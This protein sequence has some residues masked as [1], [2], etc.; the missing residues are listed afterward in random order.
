MGGDRLRRQQTTQRYRLRS[1]GSGPD[2]FTT[3][4][5]CMC[6]S[7]A[8]RHAIARPERIAN[9]L[10]ITK[11]CRGRAGSRTASFWRFSVR[12]STHR[13]ASAPVGRAPHPWHARCTRVQC[14]A[15]IPR[16]IPSHVRRP[17]GALDHTPPGPDPLVGPPGRIV[18]APVAAPCRFTATC[19]TCCHR[20]PSVR[21]LHALEARAQV[22][23]TIIVAIESEDAARRWAAARLV[24]D[25]LAALPPGAVM[26]VST[27]ARRDRFAWEHRYLL[28]PTAELTASATSWRSGRHGSI[29]SYVSLD[30]GAGGAA[31]D[32]PRLAIACGRCRADGRG[33]D[34]RGAP[35]ADRVEGRPPAAGHRADPLPGRRGVAQRAR[36][37]R[38]RGRG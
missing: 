12:L 29:R 6:A 22:F 19:R 23:G 18:A 9:E 11:H 17:L 16:P 13:R 36:R 15:L 3:R 32:A 1:A 38:G 37:R 25:R 7:E 20:R 14:A 4:W 10:T 21:D 2:L 8:H 31:P 30:E 5:S 35:G 27:T 26:G 24:R 33:Q 34:G 28:A